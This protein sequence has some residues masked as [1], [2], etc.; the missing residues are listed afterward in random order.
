MLPEP[1]LVMGHVT[2]DLIEGRER[3]GGAAAYVARALS[4]CGV[5]V[6]LVT[7]VP[8]SPLLAPLVSDPLVELHRLPAA[9]ITTFRHVFEG[10]KRALYLEER[11]PNIQPDDIPPAWQHTSL[12]FC[13]PVI[14]EC[15]TNLL[16][17]FPEAGIVA[18]VQGWLRA[19]GPDG[20]VRPAGYPESLLS[21]GMLAATLSEEDHPEAEALAARLAERCRVVTVTRG[22][23]PVTVYHEQ[24]MDEVPCA[25]VEQPRDTTGAGDVFTAVLGLRLAA[26]DGTERAVRRAVRATGRFVAERF[27][28]AFAECATGRKDQNP[29]SS[30]ERHVRQSAPNLRP[31]DSDRLD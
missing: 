7:A 10:D 20:R 1:V 14:G 16:S 9:C 19:E 8:D 26:G 24:G 27:S 30:T 2:R 18:G 15:P 11:A 13:M 29:C 23:K 25:R 21:A 4:A 28:A 12:V 3:L 17:A 6:R 22:P 31:I 5:P